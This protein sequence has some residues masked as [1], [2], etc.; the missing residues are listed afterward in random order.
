MKRIRIVFAGLALAAGL[1]TAC[2]S[3]DRETEV[4]AATA[5]AGRDL[6]TTVWQ[7]TIEPISGV[8][9]K[10]EAGG[11]VIAVSAK[12]GQ[13]IEQGSAIFEIDPSNAQL[14]LKQAEASLEAA[15]AAFQT[16]ENAKNKNLSVAPAQVELSDA[17]ANLSRM[18]SLY[19]SGYISQTD[20]DAAVSRFQ[21]AQTSLASAQ[22]SQEGNYNAAK[23]QLDSAQ[24]ALE[25]AQKK[26]D[27]CTVTAPISGQLS[28]LSVEIGETVS[29]GEAYA[30]VI[31]N[32]EEKVEIQVPDTDIDLLKQGMKMQADLQAVGAALTGSI[33]EISSVSDPQTGMY[34]VK[35]LLDSAAEASAYNGLSANVRVGE[36]GVTDSVYIPEKCIQAAEDGSS[37]VFAVK[38]G[39]AQ[40]VTVSVGRRRNA[41]R[42]ITEGLSEGDVVVMQSSAALTDGM[43]VRVLS[44]N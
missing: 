7:G 25:I 38:D 19:D 23:A 42:E 13:P 44:G 43:P 22:N 6:S 41:Y 14:S 20:Y 10:P 30:V 9:V 16:A 8:Q 2:A 29:A 15:Q 34:T 37:F 27:D 11:R 36:S 40:Q 32:S 4:T 26:L 28:S 18:Q 1:L 21:N 12:E 3:A 5:K 35:I 17:Q 33:S 24:A 31:D 39:K